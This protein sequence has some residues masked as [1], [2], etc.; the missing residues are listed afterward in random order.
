MFDVGGGGGIDELVAVLAGAAGESLGALAHVQVSDLDDAVLADTVRALEQT[1]R[2]LDATVGHVLAELHDRQATVHSAR[3]AT[4]RWL[5]RE[6]NLPQHSAMSRLRTALALR[7]HL[8]VVDDA[9]RTGR[10]GFDHARVFAEVVNDRNAAALVHAAP[11]LIDAAAHTA[12]APWRDDV[13]A[14]AEVLD[15]DGH[16]DPDTDLPS[17]RLFLS[18]TDGLVL[19]RGELAGDGAVCA[20]EAI[21]AKTD[22]LYLRYSRDRE[23]F[24]DLKIPP[25]S[26]LRGLALVELL[27]QAQ[28]ID[29]SSDAS[30]GPRTDATI[31]IHPDAHR[32]DPASPPEAHH[33]A[34]GP[35]VTTPDGTRLSKSTAA[36]LLCAALAHTLVMAVTEH[37]VP[38]AETD[39]YQPT[40]AQRRAL[41]RRDGGCTFPGCGAKVAWCDAHHIIP[42]PKGTT[43][44]SNLALLC[45]HHHRTAHRHGWTVTLTEDGW[46]R[47]TS[48]QGTTRW[49]QR[50]HRQRAGPVHTH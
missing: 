2:L 20:V 47:W 25:R 19:V 14:V 30:R 42:W 3:L 24:P 23:Q 37:G 16:R 1:R 32:S 22:E 6:A 15:P 33:G 5:A 31:V 34:D 35:V 38:I 8:P 21:E 36:V 26:E 12:F 18:P 9:L 39:A 45:R 46:T 40:R 29:P 43:V 44:L 11:E 7:D 27:R 41:A 49:G 13:R 17:N 50:H 48:P 10:I 28:G 4:S